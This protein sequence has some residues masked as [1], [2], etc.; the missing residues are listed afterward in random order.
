[1]NSPDLDKNAIRVRCLGARK[2]I[3]AERAH[4]AAEAFAK[5]LLH[6]VPRTAHAVAGYSHIHGE[7]DVMPAL[8]QLAAQAHTLCLPVVAGHGHPLV[9]RK[10]RPGDAME[11]DAHNIDIPLATQPVIVPDAL[12]VPL[13]AFDKAGHRLGYGAGYYDRTIAVLRERK[14]NL[15]LIG[16]AYALQEVDAIPAAEHDQRLDAVVTEKGWTAFA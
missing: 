4:A 9:F 7:I 3:P 11:K 6:H 15:L 1:M 13:V 8:M 5:H 2:N 12:I 10:W 16:A 14:K